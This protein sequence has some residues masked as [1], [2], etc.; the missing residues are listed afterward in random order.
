MKKLL[1]LVLVLGLASLANAWYPG[2]YLT[3]DS[4]TNVITAVA[5]S[6]ATLG[7]MYLALVVDSAGTLSSFT[8]DTN[9]PESAVSFATLPHLALASPLDTLTGELWVFTDSS[10][11]KLYL[12]GP[13]FHATFAFAA[14]PVPST[15]SLYEWYE[16]ENTITLRDDIVIVPEPATIALLCLGGLMLRRR[17]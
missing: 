2:W 6:T 14:G 15:V 16:N 10:E 7:D 12:V 11:P 8:A 5:G 3:Y 4:K 9:A 13:W 17:K 1:V